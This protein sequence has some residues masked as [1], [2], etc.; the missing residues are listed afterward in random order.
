MRVLFA[1]SFDP[2]TLGH[3]DIIT[4]AASFADEL[5]V[6]VGINPKK[7]YMFDQDK[8]VD[9][10]N[11]VVGQLGNVRTVKMEGTLIDCAKSNDVSF[12]V[13]GVRRASDVDTEL[14]QAAVNRDLGGV[15]TLFIPSRPELLLVSSSMVRELLDLGLSVSRYVPNEIEPFVAQN[16][17]K[18]G[19]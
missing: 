17:A 12:I 19:H 14:A 18:K 1:G 8:R 13:K 15:E 5:V 11:A 7:K 4:R 9:M 16:R 2:I 10:V 6:A 3:A